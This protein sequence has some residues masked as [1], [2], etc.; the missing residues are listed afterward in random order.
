M[1]RTSLFDTRAAALAVIAA[2]ALGAPTA[3][4]AATYCVADDACEAAGGIGK[5]SPLYAFAHAATT[6]EADEIRLGPGVFTANL[7]YSSSS[8]VTIVGAG[9]DKTFLRQ[10]V[11]GAPNYPRALRLTAPA[12][13]ASVVSDLTIEL[14]GTGARGLEVSNGATARRVDIVGAPMHSFGVISGG[15][16]STAEDLHIDLQG[17]GNTGAQLMG[18]TSLL[19]NSTIEAENGVSVSGG[20]DGKATATLRGLR[21]TPEAAGI[22][23]SGGTAKVESVLVDA[24]GSANVRGLWVHTA[25]AYAERK[26]LGR[27]VTVVGS[28]GYPNARGLHVKSD[29]NKRVSS[30]ELSDSVITGFSTAVEVES[31]NYGWAKGILRSS[32]HG[33]FVH[34][35]TPNGQGGMSDVAPVQVFGD[36]GFTDPAHGDFTLRAGSPLVDAG[37]TAAFFDL[38]APLDLAGA[39]RVADGDGD[40]TARRDVGAFERQAPVAAPDPK[41]IDPKDATVPTTTDDAKPT[42]PVEPTK[43]TTQ[44]PKPV[45]AIAPQLTKL[46]V[47]AKGRGKARTRTARFSVTEASTVT[48]TLARRAGKRWVAVKGSVVQPATAGQAKLVLPKKLGGNSLKPGAYRLTAVARDAAGNA[49][50]AQRATFRVA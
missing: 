21:I 32:Y 33:P 36:V 27:H 30:F 3:A 1:L 40:G 43:P 38:D 35:N 9:R 44:A 47:S 19:T 48:L 46:R 31:S 25:S 12:P 15:G 6:P 2:A 29:D 34:T 7:D 28:P 49:S 42:A 8:P 4:H 41:A 5:A 45:D 10:N 26:L 24:R 18:D 11:V 37:W 17:D 39:A 16:A 22:E 14:S 50:A 13:T 20:K 23:V